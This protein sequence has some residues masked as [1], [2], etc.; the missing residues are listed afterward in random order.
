MGVILNTKSLI[1]NLFILPCKLK[2]SFF[3]LV[4]DPVDGS[5][6]GGSG[7]N[8]TIETVGS[9]IKERKNHQRLK[10]NNSASMPVT[11]PDFVEGSYL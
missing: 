9:N 8:I 7:D 2:S 4:D 3:G 1:S 10:M 5:I 11:I 6:D